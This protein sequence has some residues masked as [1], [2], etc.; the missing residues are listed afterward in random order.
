MLDYD[1]D[2]PDGPGAE[3]LRRDTPALFCYLHAVW[4]ISVLIICCTSVSMHIRLRRA[5]SKVQQESSECDSTK[6]KLDKSISRVNGIFYGLANFYLLHVMVLAFVDAV[7]CFN[8]LEDDYTAE[9][10]TW[11]ASLIVEIAVYCIYLIALFLAAFVCLPLLQLAIATW[12]LARLAKR[13]E[14]ATLAR[15]MPQARLVSNCVALLHSMI[16]F[17]IVAFWAPTDKTVTRDIVVLTLCGSTVM[18]LQAS[19]AFNFRSSSL[20]NID[21][22]FG[23]LSRVLM[24]F[25]GDIKIA[26]GDCEAMPLPPPYK[27]EP[28]EEK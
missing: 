20:S 14:K 8:L 15:V 12:G 5:R 24:M 21:V 16:T 28:V 9:P 26:H 6:Q 18:W 27:D 1:L 7:I 11:T 17:A 25:G 10:D 22:S 19:W 3:W 2:L 4:L 23:Q 13:R